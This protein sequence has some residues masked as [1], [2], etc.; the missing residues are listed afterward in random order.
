MSESDL[1]EEHTPVG[2]D[3][4]LGLDAGSPVDAPATEADALE[5]RQEVV[6]GAGGGDQ[7][8]RDDANPADVGEQAAVVE[9]DEDDY[10]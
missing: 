2:S 4:A 1:H 6:P 5:Q 9:L 8:V 7:P 10:R 3:D